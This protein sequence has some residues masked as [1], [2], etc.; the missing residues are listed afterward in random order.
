MANIWLGAEGNKARGTC[1]YREG[2]VGKSVATLMTALRQEDHLLF[3]RPPDW[4]PPV[5]HILATALIDLRR[6]G[7]PEA[8]CR[9]DQIRPPENGWTLADMLLT[10]PCHCLPAE[11]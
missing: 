6:Y 8:S 3:C 2:N 5:R 1:Y 10:A 11:E 9:E 7:Q 4:F